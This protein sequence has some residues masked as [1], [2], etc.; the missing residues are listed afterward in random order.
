MKDMMN[1]LV[2]FERLSH[3]EYIPSEFVCEPSFR[4]GEKIYRYNIFNKPKDTG[5]VYDDTWYDFDEGDESGDYYTPKSEL[6]HKFAFDD[7]DNVYTKPRVVLHFLNGDTL[8]K[9]FDSATDALEFFERYKM[10]TTLAKN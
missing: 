3:I 5:E 7:Q 6:E 1:Q 2:S 9:R 8:T 4:K 10:P